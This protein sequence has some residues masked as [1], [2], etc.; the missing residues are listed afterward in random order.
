MWHY[1]END[2]REDPV[3]LR[4]MWKE[5]QGRGAW[6]DNQEQVGQ[7]QSAAHQRSP[8]AVVER[9]RRQHALDHGLVGAPKIETDQRYAGNQ[10]GP[11]HILVVGRHDQLEMRGVD[12]CQGMVPAGHDIAAADRLE[13]E[14]GDARRHDHHHQP[15]D[16]FHHQHGAQAAGNEKAASQH[17]EERAHLPQ[18]PVRHQYLEQNGPREQAARRIEENAQHYGQGRDIGAHELAVAQFEEL[19]HGED[20]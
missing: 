12:G 19:R 13:S 10:S 17:G 5:Q 18:R 4:Q 3:G 11:R 14:E 6:Q 15:L 20:L 9:F 1:L 2:M 8:A 16:A 7:F